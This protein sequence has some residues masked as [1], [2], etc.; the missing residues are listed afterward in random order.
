[1]LFVWL[2]YKAIYSTVRANY[3]FEHGVFTEKVK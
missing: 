3:S 2:K 1:M